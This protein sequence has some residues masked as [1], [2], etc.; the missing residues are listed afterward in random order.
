VQQRRDVR[1]IRPQVSLELGG[2]S[3]SLV[4]ESADLEQGMASIPDY[5]R[6]P[7]PFQRLRGP[8]WAASI[9][10]VKIVHAEVASTCNPQFM[11]IFW[12]LSKRK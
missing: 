5:Q 4:F 11:T 7:I 1:L 10:Q 9:I 2:K 3:P 6:P 12:A 8:L